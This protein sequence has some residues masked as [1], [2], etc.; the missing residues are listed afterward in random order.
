LGAI[1]TAGIDA[2][3]IAALPM[4]DWPERAAE[5]DAEWVSIR[6]RLRTIGVAAP[7]HLVRRNCDM[8]PAPGGIRDSAGNVIAP[9]PATLPPDEFDLAVLWR[10]PNLLFSQTCWGPLDT[11]LAEFVTVLAQPDYS[12]FEGGDRVRYSSAVIARKGAAPCAASPAAGHAILPLGLMRG[13]RL[14]YNNP[15]SMSGL[16]GLTR[17]LEA[18][19]EGLELFSQRIETG[20]HRASI[21]AVADGAADMATIDCRS[22][23]LAKRYEPHASEVEIVGWTA[24]RKGLPFITRRP[25]LLLQ[26]GPVL[27]NLGM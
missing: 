24:R 19:G 9:D 12:A 17:D 7:E 13:A 20:S 14:A 15:D 21:R 10:H 3:L 18:V 6:D 27:D 2:N 8:P 23:Q 4:Y 16:I 5:V 26:A 25:D 11:G 22:W 1:L